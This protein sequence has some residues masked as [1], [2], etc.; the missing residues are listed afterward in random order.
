MHGDDVSALQYAS[1]QINKDKGGYWDTAH[2]GTY[3][4]HTARAVELSAWAIGIGDRDLKELRQ[5]SHCTKAI[6]QWVRHPE[7]RNDSQKARAEKRRPALARKIK[8]HRGARKEI[9]SNAVWGV[10]NEPQIHYEQRRPIDGLSHPRRLPLYTD[11]SG[12][13]TDC[14]KWAGAPDPNGRGYDG[15]GFTGTILQATQHVSKTQAKAAD[16]VVFGGYPGTHVVILVDAGTH[17]DPFCVSHGQEAGPILVP[18]SVEIKAH[19]GQ[20][21]TYCQAL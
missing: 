1:N 6:Q 9:V 10:H 21:I 2:D 11:C 15:E 16:L 17:A 3:G 19:A 12:F 13:A 5:H 4:R 8:E 7:T 14:Y 18:L 20:S